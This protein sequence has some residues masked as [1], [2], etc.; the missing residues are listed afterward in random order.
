[1]WLFGVFLVVIVEEGPVILALR[2]VDE[3]FAGAM[4]HDEA[5]DKA[6]DET[7]TDH[8]ADAGI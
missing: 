7:R 1:M 4:F 8:N 5:R 6:D 3:R 2:A